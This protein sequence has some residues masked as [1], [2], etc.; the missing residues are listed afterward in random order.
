MTDAELNSALFSRGRGEASFFGGTTVSLGSRIMR[1][2]HRERKQSIGAFADLAL[3]AQQTQEF[4]VLFIHK[5]QN[6]PGVIRNVDKVPC[7]AFTL[8]LLLLELYDEVL[9]FFC[10]APL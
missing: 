10:S 4:G 8:V 3:I 6:V 5:I 9:N 7:N 1:F 2:V